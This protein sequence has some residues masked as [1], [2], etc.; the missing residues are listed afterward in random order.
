[1]ARELDNYFNLFNGQEGLRSKMGIAKPA[2][3][4]LIFDGKLVA[5]K[6]LWDGDETIIPCK[7]LVKREP[8]DMGDYG[9]DGERF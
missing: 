6:R 7:N 8:P 1:M 5:Q 4:V 3:E 9:S 2:V